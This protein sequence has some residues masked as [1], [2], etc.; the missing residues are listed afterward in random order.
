MWAAMVTLVMATILAFGTSQFSGNYHA[1]EVLGMPWITTFVLVFLTPLPWQ[2][3]GENG[4]PPTFVRGLLQAFCAM[5]FVILGLAAIDGF[6]LLKD[7]VP[8]SWRTTLQTNFLFYAPANMLVGNLIA[9]L[10]RV[11]KERAQAK[12]ESQLA[13][14]RLLQSQLHPH[15]LFNALNG[16]LELVHKDAKAAE[17]CIRSMSELFQRLLQ[18]SDQTHFRLAEERQLVEHYLALEKMRLGDRL[19]VE[20]FWEEELDGLLV[21]P[22]LLQPLVENAIKHGIA[23]AR[24]GGRIRISADRIDECLTLSVR[25]TGNP[26]P[27]ERLLAGIGVKN[28]KSRLRLAF[29][30]AGSFSLCREGDWTHARVGMPLPP[31]EDTP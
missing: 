17:E 8:F 21:P 28:L 14:T 19:E 30:N 5:E 1:F 23:P 15:V 29:G 27:D 2:Y 10:E 6:C 24:A 4:N 13:Q 11:E 12:S 22:L 7:A 16:L 20:W 18:A 26:P 25:N 3:G 31:H 9:S